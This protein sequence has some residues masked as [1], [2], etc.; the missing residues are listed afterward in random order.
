MARLT[1]TLGR[2]VGPLGTVPHPFN[3]WVGIRGIAPRSQPVL[4]PVDGIVLVKL[5][6][7]GIVQIKLPE[8]FYPRNKS[9]GLIREKTVT[10]TNEQRTLQWFNG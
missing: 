1:G 9:P 7:A 4:G 8:L 3:A 10:S 2:H 6:I 5:P